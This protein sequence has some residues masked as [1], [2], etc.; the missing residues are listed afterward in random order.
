MSSA[1][2]KTLLSY[3][4][5]MATVVNSFNSEQ[6]QIAV[7]DRLISALEERAEFNEAATP[8]KKKPP[9]PGEEIAHD[10]VEGDS[11]HNMHTE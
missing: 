5:G 11:I 7:F 10:L 6:V 3:L 8:T 4:P 9:E 2:Y 1:R